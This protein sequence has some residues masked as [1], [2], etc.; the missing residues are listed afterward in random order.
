[1]NQN[2]KC[3]QQ[4]KE[5]KK[6]QVNLLML[7]SEGFSKQDTI[8]KRLYNKKTDDNYIKNVNI[9]TAKKLK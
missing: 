8:I 2:F 1:M 7:W 3:K 5:W 4:Q 9:P 6:R